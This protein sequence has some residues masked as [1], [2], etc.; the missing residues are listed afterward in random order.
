M[1]YFRN[2]KNR[3][4]FLLS[5]FC[6][7]GLF[8]QN[9]DVSFLKNQ[10]KIASSDSTKC[11]LNYEL[12]RAYEYV[13]ADSCNYFFEKSL[14]LAIRTNNQQAVA[15]AMQAMAYTN[16]YY[17]KN[18]SIAI[19][20]LNKAII[21]ATKLNDDLILA[22]CYRYLGIIAIHQNSANTKEL[23]TTALGYAKAS[24]DWKELFNCYSLYSQ[25][26]VMT[27]KYNEAE[28]FALK[29][30]EISKKHDY[31]YW[32]TSGIDYYD[33]LILQKKYTQ[34]EKFAKYLNT[35]KDKLKMSKGYFVFMNDVARL[36]IILK[37][38][39]SAEDRL[40]KILNFET[41]KSKIDTFHLN[42]IFQN[43][44]I[45]YLKKQDFQKAHAIS[46]K[47]MEV[48]L[49]LAQ[50]RQSRDTKVLLT[51]L[52]ANLD[53]EKKEIEIKLLEAQKRQ[54]HIWLSIAIIAAILLIGF[55]I[56]LQ[57]NKKQIE[58]QR[59]ELL[60]LNT[61]KDKLFAILSHD[62]RSP[63]ASLKNYLM[64]NNWGVLNQNE[65]A[66]SAQSLNRQLELVNVTLEN[67][68]NWSITQ[69]GGMQPVFKTIDLYTHIEANIQS[70]KLLAEQKQISIKSDILP[71]T[72]VMV[73][74]NHLMI[75]IR[76]LLQ[77]AIKF[78]NI[79]GEVRLCIIKSEIYITL[80]IIDNGIGIL[81]EQ[82]KNLF[83]I[84]PNTS[85]NG[86]SNEKGTGLGLFLVKELIE[87]NNGKIFM[88]SDK[89]IGTTF[90]I[91]LMRA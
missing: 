25:L 34:A 61:T 13:S 4:V 79:G 56:I 81:P 68:L 5:L 28:P 37:D 19:A 58:F 22:Q 35:Y 69:M 63:V 9:I 67:V 14:S 31:D 40:Q 11:R 26:C 65:F 10:L 85:S 51:Q 82:Q 72:F 44:E 60:R 47:L 15:R 48:K 49:W 76:N 3:I 33:L 36:E 2:H 90:G 43:L 80:K 29:T 74:T 71:N 66:E 18:E 59:T 8:A 64:L 41:N 16:I 57:Q 39:K 6:S 53:L 17:T 75:M 54:Q 30:L 55:L 52:K 21:I 91:S 24:N 7:N 88:K 83:K 86:T 12:G 1:L 46:N 45:L 42:F 78:T 62:L 27:E 70:L 50:K 23:L 38:Y 77:N 89:N 73:D 32:F 87:I 20:W 84:S